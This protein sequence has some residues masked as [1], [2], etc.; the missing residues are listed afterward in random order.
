VKI[1]VCITPD[2]LNHYTVEGRIVVVTDIFRATSSMVTALA[3]GVKSII[4][5]KD[6]DECM[7]LKEQGMITAGERNGDKVP[8]A[9]L[10]NSPLNFMDKSL[11]GK[12]VAMTTTNGTVAINLAKTG[13]KVLIGS[14][15]NLDAVCQKL[16]QAKQ[17]VLVLCAGWKGR[18]NMEDTLFAGAVVENL[19]EDFDYD[20]DS[21]DAARMLYN[22]TKHDMLAFVRSTSHARRLKRLGV[23]EDIAFCMQMNK[24]DIVP[25]LKDGHLII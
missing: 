15:L 14:F 6:L 19:K 12:T 3:H 10:G 21:T 7:Y 23:E 24:F 25:Y 17:D 13:K 20:D 2:L 4:P 9:D 16:K 8:E 18:F 1:D 5:V 22:A 11:A